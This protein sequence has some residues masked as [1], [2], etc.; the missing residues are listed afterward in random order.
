MRRTR[1]TLKTVLYYCIEGW[2]K[3]VKFELKQGNM[4]VLS[5]DCTV[6]SF[7]AG[8]DVIGGAGRGKIA[9]ATVKWGKERG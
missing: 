1:K 2:G 3:K 8:P 4:M 7:S 6:L 5:Y 9:D